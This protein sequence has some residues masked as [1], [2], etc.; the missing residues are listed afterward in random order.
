VW[1]SI[2]AIVVFQNLRILLLGGL[3]FETKKNDIGMGLPIR[4]QCHPEHLS[5]FREIWGYSSRMIDSS[6]LS[7]A[8]DKSFAYSIEDCCYLLNNVRIYL[9]IKKNKKERSKLV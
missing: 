5:P 7:E 2:F 3:R 8:N 4:S 1:L 9:V 6:K